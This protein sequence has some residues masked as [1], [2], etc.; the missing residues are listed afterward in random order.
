[1]SPLRLGVIG[2]GL[3]VDRLHMPALAGLKDLFEVRVIGGRNPEKTRTFALA[4]GIPEVEIDA[5][6]ILHRS[7]VLLSLPIELNTAWAQKALAAGKPA[8]AEKPVAANRTEAEALVQASELP[9]APLLMIA[10]NFLF[11]SHMAEAV[12]LVKDGALGQPRLA[13]VHQ[14]QDATGAGE[15]LTGWRVKPQ[16]DGGFVL[17]CGV[18]WAA[19]IN[20]MLGRPIEVIAR[21]SAFEPGLPPIDTGAAL[22]TYEKGARALWGTAY[23]AIPSNEA[24]ITVHGSQGSVAIFWDRSEWRN[25]KEEI[26]TFT[27]PLGGYE[28]EWRHFHEVLTQGKPLAYTVRQAAQDLDLTLKIC[29]K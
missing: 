13:V 25:A 14:V 2:T 15:W 10:E 26:Q 20:A 12:R 11:W 3:A 27:S 9:G 1:M 8:M 18:H 4:Q 22:I 28:G 6:T 19:I 7:V 5:E 29:G 24:L 21:T 17:D 23:S 16:F